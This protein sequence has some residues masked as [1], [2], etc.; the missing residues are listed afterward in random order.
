MSAA[1]SQDQNAP[2][3]LTEAERKAADRRA[4]YKRKRR[5]IRSGQALMLLGA[6]IAL[7]HLLAHLEAFGGEP[8][9]F[10]DLVAGYPMGGAVALA[11]ALLA[12]Q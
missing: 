1:D 2:L 8:S 9:G 4:Q 3:K 5:K 12:G 6:L 11:G 10:T 7:T